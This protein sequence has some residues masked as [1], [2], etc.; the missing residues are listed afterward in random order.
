MAD[1]VECL[2]R[3][4]GVPR[5]HAQS[6]VSKSGVRGTQARHDRTGA[7]TALGPGRLVQEQQRSRLNSRLRTGQ[8][9]LQRPG[10]GETVDGVD[11]GVAEEPVRPGGQAAPGGR[12]RL[13]TSAAPECLGGSELG[14]GPAG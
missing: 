2:S 12:Y 3:P 10:V 7:K 5:Q 9:R 8:G 14:P 13:G 6:R 1:V 11:Q 4:F